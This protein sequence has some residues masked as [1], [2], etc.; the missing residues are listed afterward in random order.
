[1]LIWHADRFF[2]SGPFCALATFFLPAALA[3]VVAAPSEVENILG[4][5]LVGA[6]VIFLGSVAGSTATT[7]FGIVL[8]TFGSY[9]AE[10]SA[11]ILGLVG[12][13]LF[14][15]LVLHDLAG[16]FHRAPMISSRV[17]STS[18]MTVGAV[19]GAAIVAS[20]VTYVIATASTWRGIV[21][22]VGVAA[23]GFAVK[24]AADSHANSTR[25]LTKKR[26]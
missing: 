13:G 17:W 24:L 8:F 15:S 10:V 1:M 16:V 14:A 26:S 21:V 4:L 12:V 2:R 3:V 5:L 25:Q 18:A 22:P 23:V 19:S 6:L 20:A 9:L 7:G 11:F